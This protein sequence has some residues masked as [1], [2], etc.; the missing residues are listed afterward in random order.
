[1]VLKNGV[2][3][4]EVAVTSGAGNSRKYTI[5]EG[6]YN[7]TNYRCTIDPQFMRYGNGFKMDIGPDPYD[8]DAGSVRTALRIHPARS[9][10]T[11]GCIG[12]IGSS[13]EIQGFE[14]L[15]SQISTTQQS[16][17]LSVKY[18]DTTGQ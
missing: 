4:M 18:W 5:P 7:V 3:I 2:G 16:I 17:P 10:G 12:L 14:N 9:Q 13:M 6:D 1:M 8:V 15:M 11:E